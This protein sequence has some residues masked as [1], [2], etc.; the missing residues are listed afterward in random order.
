MRFHYYCTKSSNT[1]NPSSIW[2]SP[3]KAHYDHVDNFIVADQ[4]M[5]VPSAA[6]PPRPPV[7]LDSP[8]LFSRAPF[9]VPSRIPPCVR[10]E[11]CFARAQDMYTPETSSIFSNAPR[12][13]RQLF[14]ATTAP[15]F[16]GASGA[17][18]DGWYVACAFE[19]QRG[20]TSAAVTAPLSSLRPGTRTRP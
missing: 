10:P 13:A 1:S 11:F 6:R 3:A 16:T 12:D 14:I 19:R 4:S 15:F 5:T 8:M 9:R 20:T 18:R 17:E 7:G 2:Y